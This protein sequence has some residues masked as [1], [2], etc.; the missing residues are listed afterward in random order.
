MSQMY[1]ATEEIEYFKKIDYA[2]GELERCQ[3]L[4]GVY[5]LGPKI[6]R[7]LFERVEKLGWFSNLANG[8]AVR[9]LHFTHY[10]NLMS[11]LRDVYRICHIVNILIISK[12]MR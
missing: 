12:G 11:G 5:L 9:Q 10:K 2:L 8:V 3:K 4:T 1:M 6:G 7:K